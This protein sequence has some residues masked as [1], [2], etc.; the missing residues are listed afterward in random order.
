MNQQ[1]PAQNDGRDDL[2]GT[3]ATREERDVA[4]RRREAERKLAEHYE[5]SEHPDRVAQGAESEEGVSSEP[6][7]AEGEPDV[8]GEESGKKS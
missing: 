4:R 6:S 7:A 5:Q 3:P 2:T 1:T 8:P